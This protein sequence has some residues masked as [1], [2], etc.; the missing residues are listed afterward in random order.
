[1]FKNKY[2]IVDDKCYGHQCQ[3]KRWWDIFWIEMNKKGGMNSFKTLDEA[4][5]FIKKDRNRIVFHEE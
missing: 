2:R 5:E 1:M 4:K 3:R